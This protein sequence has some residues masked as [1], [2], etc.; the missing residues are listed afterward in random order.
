MNNEAEYEVLLYRLEF[1]LKLGMQNLKVFMDSKLILGHVNGIFKV[2]DKRMKA[3]CGK[4][5]KLVKKF[6][7]IDVQAKESLMPGLID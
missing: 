2:N 7:K 5:M 6:R 4:V 1:G 3:Y